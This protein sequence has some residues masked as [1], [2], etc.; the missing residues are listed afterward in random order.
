[1]VWNLTTTNARW[2]SIVVI[3]LSEDIFDR[4]ISY[5][6]GSVI[7]PKKRFTKEDPG[8]RLYSASWLFLTCIVTS[9]CCA[10]SASSSLLQILKKS[11][12]RHSVLMLLS[13]SSVT[14][15]SFFFGVCAACML[16]YRCQLMEWWAAVT[17][18]AIPSQ[19][20]LLMWP[21]VSSARPSVLSPRASRAILHSRRP[22]DCILPILVR[23]LAVGVFPATAIPNRLLRC[24][25]IFLSL[26]YF[27]SINLPASYLNMKSATHVP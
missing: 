22:A 12:R 18:V 20:A 24:H 13:L 4:C 21:C 26:R 14:N 23:K 16:S 7:L 2:V 10:F 11:S 5:I 8:S 17:D 19:P 27:P 3:F 6:L 9:I 1:M 15:L 25:G